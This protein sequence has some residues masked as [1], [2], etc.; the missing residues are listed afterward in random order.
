[1]TVTIQVDDRGTEFAKL[2]ITH[3]G[4][5]NMYTGKTANALLDAMD[6][7]HLQKEVA[8]RLKKRTEHKARKAA[9]DDDA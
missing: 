7:W 8:A 5:I 6:E 3:H 9:R 4:R 1:M 2:V